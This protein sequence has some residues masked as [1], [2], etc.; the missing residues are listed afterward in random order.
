MIVEHENSGFM[1]FK[2]TMGL[3]GF[4]FC[5]SFIHA[6]NAYLISFLQTQRSGFDVLLQFKSEQSERV[7][8]LGW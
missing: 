7:Q 8:Y 5:I 1:L 3:R 6:T 2:E 4:Y